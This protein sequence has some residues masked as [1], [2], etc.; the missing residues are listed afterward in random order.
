[1]VCLLR[2]PHQTLLCDHLRVERLGLECISGG[3]EREEG[4]RESMSMKSELTP[5]HVMK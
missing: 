4:G 1:M 3:R 2:D 5:R